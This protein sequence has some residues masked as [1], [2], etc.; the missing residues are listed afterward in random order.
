MANTSS[1]LLFFLEYFLYL[2]AE[3]YIILHDD[4][5]LLHTSPGLL[6]A[7]SKIQISNINELIINYKWNYSELIMDSLWNFSEFIMELFRTHYELIMDSLAV[8]PNGL[9]QCLHGPLRNSL[10]TS[11]LLGPC[12]YLQ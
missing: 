10:Q 5:A 8:E 6:S 3:A 4:P 2:K 7:G 11:Q 12:T 1:V 9:T